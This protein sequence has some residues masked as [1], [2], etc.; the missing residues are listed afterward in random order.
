M[1]TNLRARLARIRPSAGAALLLLTLAAALAIAAAIPAGGDSAQARQQPIHAPTPTPAPGPIPDLPP[2]LPL[3]ESNP[4]LLGNLDSMLSH[5]VANSEQ[6]ISGAAGATADPASDAAASVIAPITRGDSVAVTLHTNG[7]EDALAD[8]LRD[9][10]GDPRNI[11]DGYVEAYIP[12]S[13][14]VRASERPGVTRAHAITPPQ[15]ADDLPLLLDAK[16]APWKGTITSQG[17]AAHGAANWHTSGYTGDDVKVGVIDLG[18]TGFSDLL[19][20]ELPAAADITARC[21]TEIGTHSTT[22]AN[23]QTDTNHGTIVAESLLDIAPDATLYIS[24]PISLGDLKDTV[25]W[26]VEQDVDII[27]HSV[28]R[29]PWDGPGDGTSPFANSSLKSV[30]AAVT[31]GIIFVNSAGNYALSTWYGTFS[32]GTNRILFH[33]SNYIN[34]ISIGARKKASHFN[35]AG[36]TAG[37]PPIRALNFSCIGKTL[38]EAGTLSP[39]ATTPKRA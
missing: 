6:G 20:G 8:F 23:C 37:P 16:N 10:G 27:N 7:D 12:L 31:G 32:E 21:Y 25:D 29:V 18:F 11:H 26:M 33:E 3:A 2:D 22:L 39:K 24:N 9:N 19:G 4:L 5:L 35:C 13:L 15:P 14:L 17:V 30:D 34:T 38:E 1:R 36:T 28:S